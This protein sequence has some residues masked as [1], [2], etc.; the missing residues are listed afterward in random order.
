MKFIVWFEPERV[1]GGTWLAEK[2]PGVGAGRQGTADCWT[3]AT[4]RRA[5]G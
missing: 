2:H 3:S 4:P 5:N 1:A